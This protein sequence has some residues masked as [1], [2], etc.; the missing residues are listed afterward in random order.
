MSRII[1]VTSFEKNERTF[2][3]LIVKEPL[4]L[5]SVLINFIWR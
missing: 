4:F 3:T 5:F 2:K 1:H